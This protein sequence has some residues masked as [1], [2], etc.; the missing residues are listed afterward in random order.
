VE[1]AQFKERALAQSQRAK[2]IG[3]AKSQSDLNMQLQAA[4][5]DGTA[6][7][8]FIADWMAN[9][10]KEDSIWGFGPSGMTPA[11]TAL[12]KA[13]KQTAGINVVTRAYQGI[14]GTNEPALVANKFSVPYSD[15][16]TKHLPQLA[17]PATE[18]RSYGQ[19]ERAYQPDG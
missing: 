10:Q 7:P 11:F 14:D 12:R 18:S 16:V 13:S 17:G 19:R 9:Y 4:V 15:I 8:S 1:F 5:A 6:T 2:E 3:A